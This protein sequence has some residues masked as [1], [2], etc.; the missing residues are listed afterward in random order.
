MS[1]RPLAPNEPASAAGPG[2]AP[3]RFSLATLLGVVTALCALFAA[4]IALGPMGGFALLLVVLVLIGHIAGNSL[5]TTLRDTGGKSRPDDTTFGLPTSPPA[6]EIPCADPTELRESR[7]LGV[8]PYVGI[9]LGAGMGGLLGGALLA[10]VNWAHATPANL[11]VGAT[12][13]AILG[14]LGGFGLSCFTHVFW[15]AWNQAVESMRG[16]S[17]R[18]HDADSA[19][20]AR[21]E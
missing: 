6:G 7:P 21:V 12:A 8:V 20:Q 19:G 16:K 9:G 11:A 3:L 18:A 17:R 4:M 1:D 13:F 10:W 2:L 5:G 14:G 15:G